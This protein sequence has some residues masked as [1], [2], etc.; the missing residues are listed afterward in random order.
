MSRAQQT[1][2]TVTST[3]RRV[4][5]HIKCDSLE[6]TL[7]APVYDRSPLEGDQVSSKHLVS[8]HI[9]EE[10]VSEVSLASRSPKLAVGLHIHRVLV[11]WRCTLVA[12]T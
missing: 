3:R 1:N 11:T 7:A 10:A 9:T 5:T 8:H 4:S 6:A 12:E 2:A